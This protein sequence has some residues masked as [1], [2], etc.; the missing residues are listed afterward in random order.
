MINAILPASNVCALCWYVQKIIVIISIFPA[1]F[2]QIWKKKNHF[3]IG[4][5]SPGSVHFAKVRCVH[6]N[7]AYVN[8][9][10]Y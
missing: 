9:Q 6:R 3:V 10:N 1:T 7:P 8:L 4:M 5:G 2:Y